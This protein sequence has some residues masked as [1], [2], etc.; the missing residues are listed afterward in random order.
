MDNRNNKRKAFFEK[1]EKNRVSYQLDASQMSHLASIYNKKYKINIVMNGATEF[2][3]KLIREKIIDLYINFDLHHQSIESK[4]NSVMEESHED[5]K[6]D[7][8][9][10]INEF[11]L[12]YE[13]YL[14]L[15]KDCILFK[16]YP[17]NIILL[18]KSLNPT[19]DE[20]LPLDQNSLDL[21]RYTQLIKTFK[22]LS[23][24]YKSILKSE[25]KNQLLK[26]KIDEMFMS[27][28]VDAAGF[29]KKLNEMDLNDFSR[30]HSYLE[31]IITS[32]MESH[33]DERFDVNES[34]TELKELHDI[35]FELTKDYYSIFKPYLNEINKLLYS[36][37]QTD[38]WIPS[39]HYVKRIKT[40]KNLNNV[41]KN[42]L[43]EKNQLLKRKIAEAEMEMGMKL[44][45]VDSALSKKD[46]ITEINEIRK[47]LKDDEVIGYVFT[48]DHRFG[49][50]HFEVIIIT[51]D[52]IIKP[53]EWGDLLMGSEAITS[54][55]MESFSCL[56]MMPPFVYCENK[57]ACVPYAQAG[58]SA[59]GTLGLL[60]LKELL[61]DDANQLRNF[62]MHVPFYD[63]KEKLHYFFIPSPNVLRYS[64]SSTFNKIIR[65]MFE[66]QLD[67]IRIPFTQ[68]KHQDTLIV[69]PLV[70]MLKDTM[71]KA[72]KK[73]DKKIIE[74]CQDLLNKLPTFRT[75]WLKN[76]NL[77][78]PK[79]D[80]MQ[81]SVWNEYLTYSTH[82]LTDKA[83]DHLQEEKP[84]T[85]L[86]KKNK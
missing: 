21:D 44:D 46:A 61:K 30:Y 86:M 64:Q 56:E 3:K 10:I 68:Q 51:K 80:A 23:R 40:F 52:L 7:I 33:G 50:G 71:D 62:T 60:N 13:T 36:L 37:N 6:V 16:S 42:L 22:I 48:N 53:C 54:H 38:D 65:S 78:M 67:P 2:G 28:D 75:E 29:E 34:I 35:Y 73:G 66:D 45:A 8:N 84:D 77:A 69:Q 32:P 55:D 41:Y 27:N 70:A 11:K 5:E 1:D 74:T 19:S 43:K 12:L 24:T 26:S 83:R 31:S 59:C 79:R 20:S 4:I 15:A 57:I 18:I 14:E 49:K 58:K 39:S 76:Y 47:C 17:E 81:T 82:R 63:D 25:E 9:E 85:N 72:E